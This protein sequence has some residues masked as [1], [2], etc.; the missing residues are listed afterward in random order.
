MQRDHIVETRRLDHVPEQPLVSRCD[1]EQ[2]DPCGCASVVRGRGLGVA[3]AAVATGERFEVAGVDLLGIGQQVAL[4]PAIV[5]LNT[6]RRLRP[7]RQKFRHLPWVGERGRRRWGA[8]SM[9]WRG[10]SQTPYSL[11][12]HQPAARLH[13]S[14]HQRY[15]GEL[16]QG[17]RVKRAHVDERDWRFAMQH[18]SHPLRPQDFGAAIVCAMLLQHGERVRNALHRAPVY[19]NYKR[20]QLGL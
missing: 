15:H 3:V 13:T 20:R 19:S 8:A 12:W 10:L 18:A 2:V 17:G 16:E 4:P 11:C 6:V 9:R 14:T 7:Q 1:F 5:A